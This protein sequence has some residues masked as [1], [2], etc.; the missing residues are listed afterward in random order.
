M[1]NVSQAI[2]MIGAVLIF[3]MCLAISFYMFTR[4][5]NT[6]ADIAKM[7]SS[8][9]YYDISSSDDA[10]ANFIVQSE[11]IVGIETVIPTLYNYFSTQQVVL[12]YSGVYT[13]DTNPVTGKK[14]STL[15]SVQP[16]PLY[17]TV[18]QRQLG[19]ER[20]TLL[21]TKMNNEGLDLTDHR[22][23]GFS[24]QDEQ[25]RNEPF[26]MSGKDRNT[27][28]ITDFIN[29]RTEANGAQTYTMTNKPNY[30]NIN[31]VLGTNGGAGHFTYQ[32]LYEGEMGMPLA[33]NYQARFIERIG[34]YNYD[35]LEYSGDN[36]DLG[37]QRSYE[38]TE[39]NTAV[40]TFDL[41]G[42][43]TEK[44]DDE[45]NNQRRVIQYI[46]LKNI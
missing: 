32:Y 25:N 26:S 6:S 35:Q 46:W 12:F 1:E 15:T 28:F 30:T 37:A 16:M 9:A 27:Q 41:G 3:M 10:N 44:A 42:G 22:I 38:G 18:C 29:C 17:T 7:Y 39:R 11:K 20:S 45:K 34:V 43:D 40:D 31:W 13:E 33:Q 4:V 36:T 24:L 19:L 8:G 2:K 5:R 14:Y 21:T 23:S